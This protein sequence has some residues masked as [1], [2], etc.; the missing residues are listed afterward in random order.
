M[1]ERV[2]ARDPITDTVAPPNE[3]YTNGYAGSVTQPRP[4]DNANCSAGI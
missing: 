1:V 3:E 2:G 4:D